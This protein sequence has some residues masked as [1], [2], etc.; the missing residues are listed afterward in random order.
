MYEAWRND[1]QSFESYQRVQSK[2]GFP[3]GNLLAGFVVTEARKTVFVGMYRVDDVETCPPGSVDALLKHDIS[4]H[5]QYDLK[6]VDHL[7]T[8]RDKVVID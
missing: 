2:D 4:G 6:L 8:Y 7:A 5:F 3:V 1:R